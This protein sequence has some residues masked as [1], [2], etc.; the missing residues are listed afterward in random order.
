MRH[1]VRVQ[2]IIY[3]A[4]RR[5]FPLDREAKLRIATVELVESRAQG[6]RKKSLVVTYNKDHVLNLACFTNGLGLYCFITCGTTPPPLFSG[7]PDTYTTPQIS[8]SGSYTFA[9]WGRCQLQP[10]AVDPKGRGQ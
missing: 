7:Q 2:R 6:C 4:K 8:I 9:L 5:I 1:L 3:L 10:V